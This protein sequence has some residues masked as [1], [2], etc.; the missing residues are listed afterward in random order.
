[1]MLAPVVMHMAAQ[2]QLSPRALMMGMAVAAA[3]TFI[4]PLGRAASL[5]VMGPGGYRYVDYVKVGLPLTLVVWL[6]TVGV[7]PL[8]WPLS[9]R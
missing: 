6:V 7:L 1:V 2:L 4:N 3:S 9:A 5:M 8:V